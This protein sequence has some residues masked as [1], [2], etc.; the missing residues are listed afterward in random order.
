MKRER[1]LTLHE[2]ARILGFT[3]QTIARYCF[4]CGKCNRPLKNC[5]CGEK[6]HLFNPI[7]V[8]I[9]DSDYKREWRIPEG[10]V[11]KFLKE[12]RY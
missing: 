11:N 12:R 3:Y 7:N 2:V 9:N 5:T 4:R 10:Q 8:S 6:K 1:L